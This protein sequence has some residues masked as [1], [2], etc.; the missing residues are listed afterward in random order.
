M[1]KAK[2][3]GLIIREIFSR[4]K[5]SRPPYG[6]QHLFLFGFKYA[7]WEALVFCGD[8]PPLSIDLCYCGMALSVDFG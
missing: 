3:I 6:F 1:I 2:Y 7:V 8:S 4:R 5:E